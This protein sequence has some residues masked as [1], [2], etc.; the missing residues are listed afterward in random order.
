MPKLVKS[1][2]DRCRMLL[3]N[4]FEPIPTKP[5]MRNAVYIS[6]ICGILFP[7]V[8][9]Y[10][11]S[12]LRS[13]VMWS[14]MWEVIKKNFMKFMMSFLKSSP[15]PWCIQ[16]PVD[17][18]GSLRGVS[19]FLTWV[20][21][22]FQS[23]VVTPEFAS[24]EYSWVCFRLSRNNRILHSGLSPSLYTSQSLSAWLLLTCIAM[25]RGKSVIPHHSTQR[26]C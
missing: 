13:V 18:P 5:T 10:S 12:C 17:P 21:W 24:L 1:N 2:F 19:W 7:V 3:F 4:L 23:W 26:A 15:S 6:P 20:I 11:I 22:N 8:I 14:W 25:R 16:Y 9:T